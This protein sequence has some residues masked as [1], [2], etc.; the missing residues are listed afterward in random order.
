M[1][2]GAMG[3]AAIG[4]ARKRPRK[5]RVRREP[6]DLERLAAEFADAPVAVTGGRNEYDIIRALEAEVER[7]NAAQTDPEV[8]E[9][10]DEAEEVDPV[11]IAPDP[12][13]EIFVYPEG[14]VPARPTAP[15]DGG[16]EREIARSTAPSDGVPGNT[17]GL[18]AEQLQAWLD[19]VQDDLRKVEARVEYLQSEQTRL[20]SQYQLVAELL[21]ASTPV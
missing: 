1:E 10:V 7:V 16:F 8:I 15:S 20:Q 5:Q 19:Q 13:S 2:G 11:G 14:E 12:Q 9:T 6:I 18:P 17:V 3:A 4:F 21:A